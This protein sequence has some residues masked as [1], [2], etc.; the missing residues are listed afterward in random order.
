MDMA[1]EM[2]LYP[3]KSIGEIAYYLGFQYPQ[4]FSRAFKKSVGCTPNG[5]RR[6]NM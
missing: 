1:K 2:L 6:Q 5:Y 3:D 4:Y